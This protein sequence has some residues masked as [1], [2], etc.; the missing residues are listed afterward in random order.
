MLEKRLI[1]ARGDISLVVCWDGTVPVSA[2][3]RAA[4][5]SAACCVEVPVVAGHSES[6]QRGWGR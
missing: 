4:R 6:L 2:V 3:L 5:Q 1:T